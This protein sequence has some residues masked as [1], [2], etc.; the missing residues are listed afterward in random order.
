MK[1]KQ[2]DGYNAI[3]SAWLDSWDL[4]ML[5]KCLSTDNSAPRYSGDGLKWAPASE[6]CRVGLSGGRGRAGTWLAPGLGGLSRAQAKLRGPS[7]APDME[8]K[9]WAVLGFALASRKG[10]RR[11][12]HRVRVLWM[13]EVANAIG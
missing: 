10:D 4:V 5:S 13:L 3:Q 12:G 7:A 6:P 2:G 8:T 9:A 1:I 11:A